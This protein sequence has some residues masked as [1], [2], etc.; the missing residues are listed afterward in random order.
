MA[1]LTAPVAFSLPPN[2]DPRVPYED[3]Q[4]LSKQTF[5]QPPMPTVVLQN[6]APADIVEAAV[7]RQWEKFLSKIPTDVRPTFS[8]APQSEYY[9]AVKLSDGQIVHQSSAQNVFR[10]FHDEETGLCFS[11]PCHEVILHFQP[12]NDTT[13]TWSHELFY[14][15]DARLRETM[16]RMMPVPVGSG[17]P[18]MVFP[19]HATSEPPP[20]P[21]LEERLQRRAAK[22]AEGAVGNL[23][24]NFLGHSAAPSNNSSEPP[25]DS[26]SE[27]TDSSPESVST[28]FSPE[29]AAD[30]A[31]RADTV[32][33]GGV[34]SDQYTGLDISNEDSVPSD[35]S[36]SFYASDTSSSSVESLPVLCER[37]RD[38]QHAS[39]ADCMLWGTNLA[40]DA[41]TES[42]RPLR[43]FGDPS[44]STDEAALLSPALHASTLSHLTLERTLGERFRDAIDGIIEPVIEDLLA[45]PQTD[46]DAL[47]DVTASA[48]DLK[49]AF[50]EFKEALGRR[51]VEQ[52]EFEGLANA[53]VAELAPRRRRSDLGSNSSAYRSM[54][55]LIP[56]S[57]PGESDRFRHVSGA[58]HA[59]RVE[60]PA[61][62][63]QRGAVITRD[64]WSSSPAPSTDVSSLGDDPL[65]P[66]GIVLDT[67]SGTHST[68]VSEWSVCTSEFYIDP[69]DIIDTAI[70]RISIQSPDVLDPPTTA[71]CTSSDPPSPT[72]NDDD[73]EDAEPRILVG[74]FEADSQ[75][76]PSSSPRIVP[77]SHQ[78]SALDFWV[79]LGNTHQIQQ[80]NWE[81]Q[82]CVAPILSA[83]R[84]LHG[85]LRG[86]LDFVGMA[87]DGIRHQELLSA[88][89]L[90]LPSLPEAPS[91]SSAPDPT[92]S[93]TS[94]DFSLPDPPA[95]ETTARA[96]VTSDRPDAGQGKRKADNEEPEEYRRTS[97]PFPAEAA[98][99][100]EDLKYFAGVRRGLLEGT[101]RMEETIWQYYNVSHEHFPSHF[102]CSPLLHD[103]EVAKLHTIWSV[104]HSNERYSVASFLRDI[105]T[106]RFH[107]DS[108]LAQFLNPEYLDNIQPHVPYWELLPFHD[109]THYAGHTSGSR[110]FHDLSFFPEH[111]PR[112]IGAHHDVV[113]P[114]DSDSDMDLDLQYPASE[115]PHSSANDAVAGYLQDPL[116][117]AVS[118]SADEISVD[119][120]DGR[121]RFYVPHTDDWNAARFR[122]EWD[123]SSSEESRPDSA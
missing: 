52:A 109:E 24:S 58:S 1:S 57:P 32:L 121:I 113:E 31:V 53:I 25:T 85:P 56:V 112:F 96:S 17:L 72:T 63:Y 108:R 48:L 66:P 87:A 83:L 2:T 123:V 55:E 23:V 120:P 54:P 6:E 44:P 97:R 38:L 75:P 7:A 35:F 39:A 21:S 59:D 49:K 12:S 105:L 71:S 37:C 107:D 117:D 114:Y 89:S 106:T 22:P 69:Q 92:Q 118:D 100:D 51:E 5:R 94:L 98:S 18:P 84:T 82:A 102:K 50:V 67:V 13:R 90:D 119:G 88:L 68:A 28:P 9:G 3:V 45:L 122:A 73:D 111:A 93:P 77:L 8:A 99:I 62:D 10:L 15:S 81:D 104:L 91:P 34:F 46:I 115:S 26:S 41:D 86:Y 65:Y 16:A 78:R 33:E 29:L 76:F 116:S 42:V 47:Q 70:F 101:K 36:A 20:L 61:L 19:V 80:E 11:M 14:P 110:P 4:Y 27:S 79:R 103:F 40:Y 30:I 43:D 95:P 64:I 74:S 60:T